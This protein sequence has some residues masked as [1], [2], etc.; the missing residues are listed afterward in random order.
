MSHE[1]AP[2]GV[3]MTTPP[4]QDAARAACLSA[5]EAARDAA[6]VEAMA[7]AALELAA[8]ARFGLDPGR[9]PAL[10]SESLQATT[11]PARRTRLLSALGRVWAYAN[12]APRG[13]DFAQQAVDLAEQVGDPRL[14]ADALD[15]Q[16][17]LSWG[18]DQLDQRVVAARR[19]TDAAAH[20]DDSRTRLDAI[21]W[22]LTTAL[23]TLD[24]L[25]VG[26]QLAALELLAVETGDPTVRFFAVTRRAMHALLVDDLDRARDLIR[27]AESIGN[28]HEVPDAWAVQHCLIAELLRHAD[29]RDGLATEAR[30]YA[31]VAVDYGLQSLTAEAAVLHAE[32]GEVD[33][34]RRLLHRALGPGLAAVP[35]DVDWMLTVSKAVD[36]AALLGER[37]IAAEGLALLEPYAGRATLNAGAVIFV[38]V[39]EDFL[40]AAATLLDDSRGPAWGESAVAAY[41]R[42]GANWLAARV[43]RRTGLAP[44]TAAPAPTSARH[45]ALRPLKGGALWSVGPADAEQVLPDMRGLR[46]LHALLSRPGSDVAALDLVGGGGPVLDESGAGELLDR[47][48]L[49]SYRRRLADIDAELDEAREWADPGRAARLEDERAALLQELGAATGL[50]GRPRQA[51]GSAERARMAVRKAISAAL[52]RV[53]TLDPATARALRT[54]VRTGTSCRYEPDPDAP[55]EWLL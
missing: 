54:T 1:P 23:E 26:R 25:T 24:A 15:A 44:V 35:R 4:S 22:R 13:T 45:F 43:R 28:D 49:A 51:A 3:S 39:V 29:D 9:T 5:F 33:Q 19:L 42:L 34:A 2:G 11:D 38:G 21:L 48:A 18:P 47:Q 12:D 52:D 6:D 7:T 14:L 55:C 41:E 37:Q 36:A 16:L 17:A 30:L 46:H 10:L 53:E 31:E 8:L 32:V 40:H 27:Q 50:R 20:V